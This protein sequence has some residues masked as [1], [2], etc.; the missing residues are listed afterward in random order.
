MRP[1]LIQH[2]FSPCSAP[3][4]LYPSSVESAYAFCQSNIQDLV[5]TKKMIVKN[6]K[7]TTTVTLHWDKNI[8]FTLVST[9]KH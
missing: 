1:N 3:Y 9:R 5:P 7:K 4:P 6:K 8:L 2:T